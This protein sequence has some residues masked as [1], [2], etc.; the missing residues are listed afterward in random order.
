MDKKS[1]GRELN[2]GHMLDRCLLC[3]L[4][5][6]VKLLPGHWG[7]WTLLVFHTH[8]SNG[9]TGIELFDQRDL[10]VLINVVL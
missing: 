4:V 3:F 6:V 2:C 5:V 8:I 7:T 1:S 9:R 10:E